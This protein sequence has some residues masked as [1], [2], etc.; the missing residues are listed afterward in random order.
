MN[1]TSSTTQRNTILH[2][3]WNPL[4]RH[5]PKRLSDSPDWH[6]HLPFGMWIVRMCEPRIIVELGVLKGDSYCSFCQVVKSAGLSTRCFGIDTWEGDLHTGSYGEEIFSQL[7]QYHDPKY[8]GFSTLLRSTFDES[9]NTFSDGS[10][11]LL[12]IDGFHSYRAVRH[13]FESWLPKLSERAV[14]LF[15]D[16][17]VIQLSF[18]VWRYWSQLC[19]RYP[20]FSFFHSNGLGVLAVGKEIPRNIRPLFTGSQTENNSIRHLFE[21]LGTTIHQNHLSDIPEPV[22]EALNSLL[23]DLGKDK[24]MIVP[25]THAQQYRRYLGK[26][27]SWAESAVRRTIKPVFRSLAGSSVARANANDGKK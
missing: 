27:L 25:Y 9:L 6:G 20:N 26:I 17:A 15:H 3:I 21:N 14:V 1:E 5:T 4:L 8:G 19:R 13:D 10:I 12:H 2:K 24:Y 16:T 18:G 22:G 11:D 7:R 23:Y